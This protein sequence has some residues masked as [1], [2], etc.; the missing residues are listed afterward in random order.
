MTMNI[1]KKKVLEIDDSEFLDNKL[2][3]YEEVQPSDLKQGDHLRITQNKYQEEGRKCS[4]IVLKK[5]VEGVWICNSYKP[6][7][8]DWGIDPTNKFKQIRFYR[9]PP[10][11]YTGTCSK[12]GCEVKN[13]Y[14]VCWDCR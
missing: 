4:Y 8:N 6:M 14:T 3:G 1:K 2:V 7:Y 10:R 11:V 12:C 5:F 9:K 13:P